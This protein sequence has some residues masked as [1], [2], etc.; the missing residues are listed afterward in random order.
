MLRLD[1]ATII[2]VVKY[3]LVLLAAVVLAAGVL[4]ILNNGRIV[5]K[6]PAGVRI[7]SFSYCATQ[8]ENLVVVNNTDN[9]TVPKGEYVI[10]VAFDNNTEYVTNTT[11]KGLLATTTI[12]AKSYKYDFS[13]MSSGSKQHILPLADGLLVYDTD[14]IASTINN[15][16]EP[17]QR[18]LAAAKRLDDKRMLLL[19]GTFSKVEG[20]TESATAALYD[21]SSGATTNLGTVN[22]PVSSSN[23]YYGSNALYALYQQQRKIIKISDQ[24]ISQISLPENISYASNGDLPLVALN[25]DTLAVLSGNDF[26]YGY[27]E[28]VVPTTATSTITIYSLKDF[29]K[30]SQI[31]IGKRNDILGLSLSPDGSFVVAIGSTSLISFDLKASKALLDVPAVNVDTNSI[32]WRNNTSYIYQE[33]VGGLYMADLQKSEAFSLIDTSVIRINYLSCV[34]NNKLYLSGSSVQNTDGART[35]SSSYVVNLDSTGDSTITI[36]DS[37]IL[38]ALPYSEFGYSIGYH[39]N[40]NSAVID[41]DADEHSHNLALRDVYNLGYD[42]ANYTFNFLN[43]TSPFKENH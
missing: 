35:E 29:S 13:A 33:G 17:D 20:I 1:R 36:D 41:I 34:V 28:G 32:V 37:S 27:D 22:D 38:R 21:Q 42:P 5:I 30:I 6:P 10:R 43:Y 18:P 9:A 16:F 24:G 4:Y 19:Y 31:D 12:N 23:V 26:N 3:S 15:S 25:G 7:T 11:V 40:N 14:A 8:C 39:L 2:R